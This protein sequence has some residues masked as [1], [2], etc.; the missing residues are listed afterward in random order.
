MRLVRQFQ[1]RPAR[2]FTVVELV[3]VIMVLGILAVGTTRFLTDATD[4]FVSTNSRAELVGDAQA[5]LIGLTR[6]VRQALPRTLRVAGGGQC[7][8]FI[9]IEHGVRYLSAPFGAAGASVWTV[10]PSGGY[11]PG[12]ATRL[13]IQGSTGAYGLTSP[14]IVSGVVS[15]T[16]L[17]GDGQYRVD[18]AAAHTFSAASAQ[19]RVYFVGAPVSYCV[20][21]GRLW[22][23]R[24]YGFLA[25]QPLPA[26]LPATLPQRVLV[27]ESVAPAFPVFAYDT[28]TLT[29]NA[30]VA[31]QLTVD[32]DGTQIR[33]DQLIAIRN[34][35]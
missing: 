35:P 7:L 23:Y 19:Q 29:R 12:A 32:R 10:P 16:T 33:L 24:N 14:G 18:L 30:T 25:V 26:D 17:Q 22:R 4:G 28:A 15:A 20:D 31:V 3:T 1:A 27:A 5:T 2:G 9:P 11:V 6:D 21:G 34:L 13:A 8:E